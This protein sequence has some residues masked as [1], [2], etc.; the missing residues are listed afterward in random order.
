MAIYSYK[1]ID[2]VAE[3][4]GVQLVKGGEVVFERDF[5]EDLKTIPMEEHETFLIRQGAVLADEYLYGDLSDS[6]E[7]QPWE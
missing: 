7:L 4:G 2:V 6:E 5:S 3:D 1:G